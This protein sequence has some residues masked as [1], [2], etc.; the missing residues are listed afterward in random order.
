MV[1][2]AGEAIL[3]RVGPLVT[4][5]RAAR[6][7]GAVLLQILGSFVF[8]NLVVAVILENFVARIRQPFLVSANDVEHFKEVWAE[9]DPDANF[10]LRGI[11]RPRASVPPPMGLG[12]RRRR[13]DANKL[14]ME[15]HPEQVQGR[16]AFLLTLR[17]FKRKSDIPPPTSRGSSGRRPSR[18]RPRHRQDWRGESMSKADVFAALPSVRRAFAL[19][20]IERYARGWSA[21]MHTRIK[22]QPQA[23]EQLAARQDGRQAAQARLAHQAAPEGRRPRT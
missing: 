9:F 22:N 1:R 5:R 13:Q 2:P 3:A 21:N 11:C 15:L 23:A 6:R 8:L 17:S 18:C 7:C 12:G 10:I 19:Q 4:A 16:V 14:C 20:V